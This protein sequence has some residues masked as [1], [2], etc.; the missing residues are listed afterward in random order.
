MLHENGEMLSQRRRKNQPLITANK[1]RN[2]SVCQISG[3]YIMIQRKVELQVT[4]KQTLSCV[5]AQY[6]I[7]SGRKEPPRNSLMP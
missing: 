4:L 7:T 5:C 3:I 6:H 1:Q 2:L